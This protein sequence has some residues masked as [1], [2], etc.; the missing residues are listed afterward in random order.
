[1]NNR[2]FEPGDDGPLESG[3]QVATIPMDVLVPDDF[4]G[5]CRAALVV[6]VDTFTRCILF[7]EVMLAPIDDD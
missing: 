4:G 6:C 1:M 7:H 3:M 5:L 2:L